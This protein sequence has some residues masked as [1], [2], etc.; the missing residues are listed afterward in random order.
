M[1]LVNFVLLKNTTA[2]SMS[3]VAKCR[4]LVAYVF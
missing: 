1:K 2:C 4:S 3:I